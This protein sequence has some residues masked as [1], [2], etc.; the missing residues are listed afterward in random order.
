VLPF[1][2]GVPICAISFTS[3]IA[4][5]DAGTCMGYRYVWPLP[6]SNVASRSCAWLDGF[7]I[8]YIVSKPPAVVQKMELLPAL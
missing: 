4:V 5:P 6:N 7:Q 1:T 3:I 8:E 2:S